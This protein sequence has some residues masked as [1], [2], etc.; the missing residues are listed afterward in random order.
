MRTRTQLTALAV[1]TCL[2]P[3]IAVAGGP[4]AQMPPQVEAMHRLKGKWKGNG[5]LQLGPGKHS[6]VGKMKCSPISGGMGIG[7][8]TTITGSPA[9]EKYQVTDLWGY[10]HETGQ[11]HMFSVTNA[12]ETHDHVGRMTEEGWEGTYEGTHDGKPLVEKLSLQFRGKDKL[13]I[14]SRTIIGGQ[15]VMAVTATLER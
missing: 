5:T 13:T 9:M 10:D 15:Q 11:H 1:A 6:V 7:C 14:S 4:P 2:V 8:E 3:L 12:G